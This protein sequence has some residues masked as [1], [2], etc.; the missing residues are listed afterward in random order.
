MTEKLKNKRKSYYTILLELVREQYSNFDSS[1][2][3]LPKITTNFYLV[4]IIFFILWM[5]FFDSNDVFSQYERRKTLKE[6]ENDKEFYADGIK[7]IEL[8]RE[9]L[10]TNVRILERFARENYYLKKPGEDV[11]IIEEEVDSTEIKEA[12]KFDSLSQ[13]KAKP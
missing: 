4:S 2:I 12:M 10:S 3:K 1:K 9:K 6:L 5:L 8:K 13:K 11:Y 7:E